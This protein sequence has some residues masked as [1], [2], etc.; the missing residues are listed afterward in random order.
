MKN[1]KQIYLSLTH[2]QSKT[3]EKEMNYFFLVQPVVNRRFGTRENLLVAIHR[4]RIGLIVIRSK[5]EE[6]SFFS[7]RVD[8]MEAKDF[9]TDLEENDDD[10]EQKSQTEDSDQPGRRLLLC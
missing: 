10:K 8:R 7:R 9:D 1:K 3:K 5:K 4:T 6:K 2:T